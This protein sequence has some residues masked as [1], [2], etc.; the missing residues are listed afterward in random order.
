MELATTT[1]AVAA[2][3]NA[4]RPRTA[5]LAR[6]DHRHRA[7]SDF[8]DTWPHDDPDVIAVS[9]NKEVDRVPAA[10][11]PVVDLPRVAV[12]ASERCIEPDDRD[13]ATNV[14]APPIIRLSRSRRDDDV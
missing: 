13:A 7:V 12:N 14:A 4:P 6:T 1:Y 10:L 8:N 5:R 2:T 9:K 11:V 3:N